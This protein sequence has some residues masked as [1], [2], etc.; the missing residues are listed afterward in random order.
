MCDTTLKVPLGKSKKARWQSRGIAVKEVWGRGRRKR[1]R[2][3][4]DG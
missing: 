1:R 4:C 3:K 2:K